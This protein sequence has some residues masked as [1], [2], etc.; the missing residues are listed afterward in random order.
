MEVV[1]AR[2]RPPE[3]RQTPTGGSRY[4]IKEEYAKDLA[5]WESQR[6]ETE[7]SFAARLNQAPEFLR[8]NVLV[9]RGAS[10]F[11]RGEFGE[12]EADFAQVT[13]GPRSEI[14]SLMRARCALEKS[15]RESDP[16]AAAKLRHEANRILQDHQSQF[17]EGR[18]GPDVAGWRG[19]VASDNGWHAGAIRHY[20]TQYQLR[21]TRDNQRNALREIERE[22]HVLANSDDPAHHLE[23]DFPYDALAAIPVAAE[24][25][26]QMALDV[27]DSRWRKRAPTP[28]EVRDYAH[29]EF[30]NPAVWSSEIENRR[31]A[32]H[33]GLVQ[34]G[35]AMARLESDGS[36]TPLGTRI[37]AW[38]ATASGDH[39]VAARLARS[40]IAAAADSS[41]MLVHAVSLDR[42][43]AGEPALDAY[44]IDPRTHEAGPIFRGGARDAPGPGPPEKRIPRQGLARALDCP[45]AN[46]EAQSSNPVKSPGIPP[47]N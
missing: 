13:N 32:F 10:R 8:P 44:E 26:L 7:K 39:E 45:R 28:P 4:W 2:W 16:R 12:A 47:M 22:L 14:A 17:P 5:D 40:G 30:N 36:P 33:A 23:Y 11:R 1:L 29:S 31:R 18:L 3:S 38:A 15:R 42:M 25:F 6:K 41:L 34:L 20:L 43:E 9:Q 37:Q 19:A 24:F 46:P 21:A 27:P 35:S